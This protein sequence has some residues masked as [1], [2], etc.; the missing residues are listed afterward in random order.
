MA[1]D[2][3]TEPYSILAERY[4]SAQEHVDLSVQEVYDAIIALVRN[5]SNQAKIDCLSG[6]S[7][8]YDSTAKISDG[9]VPA[10]RKLSLYAIRSSGVRSINDF[11]QLKKIKVRAAWAVLSA[12]AG[13]PINEEFIGHYDVG[14]SGIGGDGQANPSHGSSSQ[15]FVPISPVLLAQFGTPYAFYNLDIYNHPIWDYNMIV[16]YFEWFTDSDPGDPITAG[17]VFASVINSGRISWNQS[18]PGRE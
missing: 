14:G 17:T 8:T 5:D 2:G 16:P 10:V 6:F 12:L 9:F 4:A 11:L 7:E 15:P 18:H 13:F 3:R 1:I